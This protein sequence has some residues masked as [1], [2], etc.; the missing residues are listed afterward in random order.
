MGVAVK[1]ALA[2][3]GLEGVQLKWPNDIYVT[4]KKLGGILLEMVGDPAGACSVIV[5]VGVNVKM[6]PEQ[7]RRIDQDWTDVEAVLMSQNMPRRTVRSELVAKLVSEIT[8][9]L[10]DYQEKGFAAYRDEWQAADA[11]YGLR[12]AI[13]TPK[14]T[15]TGLVRGVDVNG[16]LCLEC[17]DGRVETFIGGELSLMVQE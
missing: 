8:V 6:P 17:S 4:G 11:F 5:G 13:I 15:I 7:G 10:S 14:E 12:A 1:R 3:Q 2:S 16:A 9:V